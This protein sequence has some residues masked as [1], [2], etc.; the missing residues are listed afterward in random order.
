MLVVINRYCRPELRPQFLIGNNIAIAFS[1]GSKHAKGLAP[2][3]HFK[4]A[5]S[6]FFGVQVHFENFEAEGSRP[7]KRILHDYLL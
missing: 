2:Q 3:L 5:F 6:Y 4:A 7:L 1:D